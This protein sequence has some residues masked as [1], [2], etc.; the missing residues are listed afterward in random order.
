M[1]AVQGRKTYL[2]AELRAGIVAFLTICYIIAVGGWYNS[3]QHSPAHANLGMIC[4]LLDELCEAAAVMLSGRV[5][6]NLLM[7]LPCPSISHWTGLT[8]KAYEQAE[9]H[10]SFKRTIYP[11]PRQ[12]CGVHS[13]GLQ[14]NSP[15]WC[16][17]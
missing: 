5:D 11:A 8:K 4:F 10:T 1:A 17:A 16:N 14:S 13:L 7:Q 2:T 6:N 15:Y 3:N 9:T 12:G